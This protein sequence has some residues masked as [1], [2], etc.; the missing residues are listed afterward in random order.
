LNFFLSEN[1]Q[2]STVINGQNEVEKFFLGKRPFIAVINGRTEVEK[3]F[4]DDQ[5]ERLL[6]VEIQLKIV[7]SEDDHF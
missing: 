4:E 6:M 2:F 3:F 1:R 5:F 7:F